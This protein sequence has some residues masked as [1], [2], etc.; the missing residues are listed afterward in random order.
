M[1]HSVDITLQS[2][3]R[4]SDLQQYHEVMGQAICTPSPPSI[5]ELDFVTIIL[6]VSPQKSTVCA[7]S[8]VLLLSIV[9][10]CSQG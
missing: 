5:S 9:A 4:C 2:Q 7:R 8:K 6:N 3:R 1:W 10:D